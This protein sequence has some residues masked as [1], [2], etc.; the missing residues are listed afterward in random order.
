MHPFLVYYQQPNNKS[1]I[2]GEH[3]PPQPKLLLL[4]KQL[5]PKPLLQQLF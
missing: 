4:P 5:L 3:P 2:I 1:H